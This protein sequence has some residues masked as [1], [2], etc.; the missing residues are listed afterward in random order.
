MNRNRFSDYQ[1]LIAKYSSEGFCGH[2]IQ[3]GDQIGR[4]PYLKRALCTTCWKQWV[5]E[6][7]SADFDEA[8]NSSL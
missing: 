3:A 5:M 1:F 4:N 2:A 7:A 6:N 8:N